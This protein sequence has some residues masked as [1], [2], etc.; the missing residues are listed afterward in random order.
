MS[1]ICCRVDYGIALFIVGLV[2]TFAGQWAAHYLM[3]K[4]QRRSELEAVQRRVSA[5][6]RCPFTAPP[7]RI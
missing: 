5:L 2:F 7:M 1:S 4:L 3:R 6:L